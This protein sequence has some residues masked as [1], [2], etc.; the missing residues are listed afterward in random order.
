M[1]CKEGNVL[2][3]LD[4]AVP[5]TPPERSLVRLKLVSI[6]SSVPKVVFNSGHSHEYSKSL[7]LAT[8]TY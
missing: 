4:G 6:R 1:A 3:K 5:V 8:S 7:R 2:G